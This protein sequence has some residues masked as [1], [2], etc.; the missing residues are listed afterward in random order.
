[1][2]SLFL[3]G[4]EK[5]LNLA[6]KLS[7]CS[8]KFPAFSLKTSRYRL[9]SWLLLA[10]KFS[11]SSRSIFVFSWNS[12]S[13]DSLSLS[14]LSIFSFLFIEHSFNCSRSIFVFSWNLLSTDFFSLSN[15]S[16]F[17]FKTSNCFFNRSSRWR[18]EFNFLVI[19][20]NFLS[21]ICNKFLVFRLLNFFL[22]PV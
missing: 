6:P 16:I 22:G 1:M 18:L 12:L 21:V 19:R 3:S 15:P 20:F 7:L 2:L 11:N 10:D 5:L 4:F 8:Y 14:S 17:L 9:T 13:T